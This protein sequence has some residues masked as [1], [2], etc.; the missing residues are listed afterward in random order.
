MESYVSYLGVVGSALSMLTTAYFWFVRIR[1]E[2]PNL[3]PHLVDKEFFLGISR[4]G[5][6][7]VG[8]KI[9]FIVANYSILPNAIL[10]AR[11]W[12]RVKDGWQ[13]VGSL[14]FD[15]QTPQPFNLTPLQ[16]TLLRLS[17][18]LSFPYQDELEGTNKALANYLAAFLGQPLEIKLELQHL[19]RRAD[20]HVMTLA[21]PEQPVAQ[22][23]KPLS[24]AA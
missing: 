17:G 6:R 12:I 11:L 10:G 1:K 22:G 15:K 18:T 4:D 8:L 19:N 23:V 16:T 7:Q 3:V 5:V 2:Q 24:A 20:A 21:T 14:A 9:G 13:E